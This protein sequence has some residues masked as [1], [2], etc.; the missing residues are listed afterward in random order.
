MKY[1]ARCLFL[2]CLLLLSF[3]VITPT[4]AQIE[5]SVPVAELPTEPIVEWMHIL[6][7]L[8]EAEGINP[9]NAARFFAYAGI[10]TYESLLHGMPLN[11]TLAG[12]IFTMPDLP[13]PDYNLTYDWLTVHNVA[14]STVLTNLFLNADPSTY[15]T[16][17]THRDAQLEART[18]IVGEDVVAN[19]LAYGDALSKTLLE[20]IRDDNY[21]ATRGLE[22]ELPIGAGL[23]EITTA[24]AEPVEPYWGEIRPFILDHASNCAVWLD[25]PYDTDE[26]STFY[27]QAVEVINAERNLTAEQQEIAP[28]LGGYS[29]GLVV[30]LR[31]IGGQSPIK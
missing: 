23:W 10:T 6:Y 5:E 31:G 21:M 3:T 16:I 25:V 17:R 8:I 2:S 19:S 12:Q 13:F 29:Q 30:H 20:W 24:G 15:E 11:N 4:K 28:F 7:N 14:F 22:Y 1:L 9:P 18:E 27:Q 26:N